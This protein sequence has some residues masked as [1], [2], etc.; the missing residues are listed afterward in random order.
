VEV[1]D[2]LAEW[3][4][5][6]LSMRIVVTRTKDLEVVGL[7]DGGFYSQDVAALVVHLDGVAVDPVLHADALVPV[8]EAGYDLGGEVARCLASE[9][10]HDI[11]AMEVEGCG[12]TSAG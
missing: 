8:F 7:G 9:E 2:A 1:G 12:R 11:G 10:A 5:L 6:E 3:P 4:P